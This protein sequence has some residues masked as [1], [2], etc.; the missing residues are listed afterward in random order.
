M[1]GPLLTEEEVSIRY[2][3][4]ARTI[5]RW[6]VIGWGPPFLRIGVKIFY[7]EEDVLCYER[8]NLIASNN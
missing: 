2:K 5:A 8:D 6:R 7:R 3:V 4:T 1:I